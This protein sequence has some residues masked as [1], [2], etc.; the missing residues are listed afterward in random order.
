MDPEVT[1]STAAAAGDVVLESE[2][3]RPTRSARWGE[4][5]GEMVKFGAVAV[6]LAV[7]VLVIALL[8]PLIFGQ[9]VPAI[10]GTSLEPAPVSEPGGPIQLPMIVVPGEPDTT[11]EPEPAAEPAPAEEQPA[12][13][14]PAIDPAQENE[15][16]AEAAPLTHIVQANETLTSIARQYGVTV[17]ALVVANGLRNPNRI[18]AGTTL[19]IPA[20][21]SDN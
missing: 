3:P 17:E 5:A 11:Q 2:P 16:P 19:L 10:M 9:I 15:A 4:G 8:R 7:T 20:A 6:V 12:D 13:P 1:G 14:E 18:E 21:P